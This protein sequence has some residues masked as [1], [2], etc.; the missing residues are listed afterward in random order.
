[1]KTN[2]LQSHLNLD[3]N[4]SC[5][6][7]AGLLMIGL[8]FYFSISPKFWAM[9]WITL[10]ISKEEDVNKAELVKNEVKEK[11]NKSNK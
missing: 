1:M 2:N 5:L 10:I 9:V 6:L 7:M 3:I 8:F 4:N 11:K